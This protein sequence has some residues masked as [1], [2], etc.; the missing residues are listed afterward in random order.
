VATNSKKPSQ[1]YPASSTSVPPFMPNQIIDPSI[2]GESFDQL[3]QNRGIRF[4]H[5]RAAPCPN[6]EKLTDNSHNPLC[7]ICNGN[8]FLYYCEKEIW[9][10]FVSNSLE[11][12]FEQQGMWEIGTAVVTFPAL[13]PDGT[14]AEFNTYDQLEIDDF[15][16]RL[17]ELKEYDPSENG[18]VTR[19]RY[20]V[21]TIDVVTSAQNNVRVDFVE[22]TDFTVNVDGNL[23]WI[24]GREPSYDAPN[25][26]GEVLSIVY[27][28]N[29]RYNVL[30]QMRELRITQQLIDGQK[31]AI[32]L[33]QQILVKRDFLFNP[34]N[35]E[36]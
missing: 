8:G 20:P 12:N 17:W 13:Y 11:K 26:K 29:P 2:R 18:G 16:V 35:S 32:R 19:M 30:Q 24:A 22:G 34:P 4:I 31:T 28:A 33:P 7:A 5:K 27:H 3:I 15:P 6:M 14:V 36:S 25:E 21:D 1:I 23:A 10:I 9:G